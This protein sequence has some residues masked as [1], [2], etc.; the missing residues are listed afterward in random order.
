MWNSQH[1]L[2]ADA[3]AAIRLVLAGR[4][5]AEQAAAASGLTLADIRVILGSCPQPR[6]QEVEHTP[7][8]FRRGLRRS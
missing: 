1:T 2:D 7:P 4:A 3:V 6:L 8:R 5:S